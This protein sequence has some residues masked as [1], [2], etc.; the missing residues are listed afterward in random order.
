MVSIFS[1]EGRVKETHIIEIC[2]K[3]LAVVDPLFTDF[4]VQAEQL[5]ITLLS[6]KKFKL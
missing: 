2:M 6:Y 1:F 3:I 5:Y 4:R